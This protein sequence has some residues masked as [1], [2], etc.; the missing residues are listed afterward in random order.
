MRACLLVDARQMADAVLDIEEDRPVAEVA[1]DQLRLKSLAIQ[2]ASAEIALWHRTGTAANSNH[3][4]A[5]AAPVRPP[6]HAGSFTARGWRPSAMS[7]SQMPPSMRVPRSVG[8]RTS[9]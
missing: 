5:A 9:Q 3:A 7:S 6:Y 1:R 2:H 8:R 4:T